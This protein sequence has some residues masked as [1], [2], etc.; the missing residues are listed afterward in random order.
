MWRIAKSFSR[1]EILSNSKIQVFRR[2][3]DITKDFFK[4]LQSGIH[5][6]SFS[7]HY[8][9][10]LTLVP[11]VRV[12]RTSKD[13]FLIATVWLV[14]D[15]FDYNYPFDLQNFFQPK[16]TKHELSVAV[17]LFQVF[18][19]VEIEKKVLVQEFF[20]SYSSTLSNQTKTQMKTYFIQLVY[21]LRDQP[22]IEPNYKIL[23]KGRF[24]N[25]TELTITNIQE[26]FLFYERLIL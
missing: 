4:S 24:Y 7:S 26:G 16:L 13:K 17:K 8:F 6:R 11:Q 20:D 2:Q 14:N 5:A 10:S 23:T 12:E 21:W 3:I 19:S 9:Q 1:Y 18:N 25:L 22:L 15:L